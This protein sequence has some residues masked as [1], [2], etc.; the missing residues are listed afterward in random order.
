M[1]TRWI[2]SE[3]DG[4]MFDMLGPNVILGPKE[5]YT[6]LVNG[7]DAIRV[8]NTYGKINS[9]MTVA[10]ILQLSLREQNKPIG[11]PPDLAEELDLFHGKRKPVF[12]CVSDEDFADLIWHLCEFTGEPFEFVLGLPIDPFLS[13]SVGGRSMREESERQ[14]VCLNRDIAEIA[15]GEHVLQL[16]GMFDFLHKHESIIRKDRNYRTGL[17]LCLNLYLISPLVSIVVSFIF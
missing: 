16:A 10:H 3:R 1:A 9:H 4:L 15:E 7:T 6:V 17:A 11:C 2:S 8:C 14:I 5:S 13:V 12:W